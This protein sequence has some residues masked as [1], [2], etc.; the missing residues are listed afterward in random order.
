MSENEKVVKADE[1]ATEK[2]PGGN[3][4]DKV[5]V[6]L[7]EMVRVDSAPH[8]P[9]REY[10]ATVEECID[11]ELKYKKGVY[12]AIKKFRDSN[13]WRGTK[14]EMQYK[15][16]LLNTDLAKIYEIPEPK[17]VFVDKFP[18]GPCCFPH[19]VPAVIMM[20]ATSDG[21][22]SVV[23]FL[24]EF[25]HA[26]GRDEK[27]ACKWSLNLFKRFFPKSY[28]KLEPRGHMLYRKQEKKD[29]A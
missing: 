27:G 11:D 6:I 23:A 3:W 22:Y 2:K 8:D 10:P 29:A 24:H 21:R 16:N 28:E 14:P 19:S 9:R 4:L 7:V 20:E 17:L 18:V 26:I 1:K 13:P 5:K 25:A 15:Y 12:E